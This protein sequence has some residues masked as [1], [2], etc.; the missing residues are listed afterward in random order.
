MVVLFV[1]FHCTHS[2][3]EH[4]ANTSRLPRTIHYTVGLSANGG[5]ASH[6]ICAQ[7]HSGLH[8]P[9]AQVQQARLVANPG[10]Y[11]TCSILPLAPLLAAKLISP[12]DII[13]DA[14]SGV[15]GAGRAAKEA[16][17]YTEVAEGMH[18]YG[19]GHHRHM[20]EIE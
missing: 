6:R 7:P 16:N 11:P 2:K 12:D 15:S 14:K 5:N 10:C 13:I 3:A 20:P 18:S 4:I 17:L 19:V 8:R 9:P 1:R